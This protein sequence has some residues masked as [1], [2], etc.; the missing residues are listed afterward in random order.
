MPKWSL[1]WNRHAATPKSKLLHREK[2]RLLEDQDDSSD[3]DNS[4]TEISLI[5]ERHNLARRW[6]NSKRVLAGLQSVL[7]AAIATANIT[8][9]VLVWTG[10]LK[11][12]SIDQNALPP[13][14]MLRCH[15]V[16]MSRKT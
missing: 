4:F 13:E 5:D 6:W 14:S 12:V 8:L 2:E 15:D 10:R 16:T 7:V 11:I 9:A 1:P 3:G